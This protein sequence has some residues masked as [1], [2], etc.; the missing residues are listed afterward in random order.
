MIVNIKY[1]NED[2]KEFTSDLFEEV[3]KQK[4]E[5]T[6]ATYQFS[7]E[8]LM[9]RVS[10]FIAYNQNQLEQK[11]MPKTIYYRSGDLVIDSGQH[12]IIK[13][14]KEV[15]LTPSS[16]ALLEELIIHNGNIVTRDCLKFRLEQTHYHPISDNLLN[17]EIRRLR[18]KLEESHEMR[19][20]SSVYG[21]GYRWKFL[22]VAE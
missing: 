22:I 20:I 6:T 10:N 9:N 14:Q 8:E 4:V 3:K 11:R 5:E 13:N 2:E 18:Q 7:T 17:V 21:V 12:R 19:Y 1:E 15:Y 16:W